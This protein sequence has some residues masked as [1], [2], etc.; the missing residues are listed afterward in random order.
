MLLTLM[1]NNWMFT[2]ERSGWWRMKIAEMTQKGLDERNA[3]RRAPEL[4]LEDNTSPALVKQPKRRLKVV[5][6][7]TK[8]PSPESL[9]PVQSKV[10]IA[11]IARPLQPS[12]LEVIGSMDFTTYSTD[13]YKQALKRPATVTDLASRRKL[14]QKREEEDFLILLAA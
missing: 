4:K 1:G 5:R 8:R 2:T 11:P 9:V 10:I 6:G 3:L 12:M 7:K 14:K 13:I